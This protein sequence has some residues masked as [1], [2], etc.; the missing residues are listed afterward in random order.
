MIAVFD[1][2]TGE[3]RRYVT[4]PDDEII[5][6]LQTGEDYITVDGSRGGR[7]KVV[8]GTLEE[9][10]VEAPEPTYDSARRSAYP[11]IT[12]QLDALWHAMDAGMLPKVPAFYDPIKEVKDSFPKP[13]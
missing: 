9:Y 1:K 7:W 3:V 12:D 6:N 2:D 11:A 4:C 13:D 10:T 5:H 8:D